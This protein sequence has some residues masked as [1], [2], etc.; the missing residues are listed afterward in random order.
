MAGNMARLTDV[1]LDWSTARRC[2][3]ELTMTNAERKLIVTADDFGLSHDVNNAV[4]V[5]HREGIL[6]ATSLMVAGAAR[7]EAA[8]IAHEYPALDVGLHATVCLGRSVLPPDRLRGIVD[9]KGNFP[10]NPTG[11]GMRYYFNRSIRSALKDELR[12]QA[13]LHLQ[14]IGRLKHIDGHLNFHVHPAIADVLIRLC[15][16]YH[17]PCMRLPREPVFT[18][19]ALARDSA[20]RKLIEAVIFHMLSWRAQRL[21]TRYGIQT[22]DRLFGLHQSGHLS[23]AYVLGVIERLPPG[24]TE[25]YFHPAMPSPDAPSSLATH[26]D[27]KL[28]INPKVRAAIDARAIGLTNFAEISRIRRAAR[29]AGAAT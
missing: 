24:L 23:E 14:L 9:G 26:S 4:A 16:E 17:V 12:A 2:D 5:A 18:T 19:L 13:E 10:G 28:L 3:A 8:A 20:P 15:R 7:D 25:F 6:T 21:M 22:T 11:A 29:T 27:Y 1:P